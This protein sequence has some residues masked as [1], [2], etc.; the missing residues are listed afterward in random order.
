MGGGFFDAERT[1]LEAHRFRKSDKA[2]RGFEPRLLDSGSRVLAVT[3]R[4]RV[5]IRAYSIIRAGL[6][7]AFLKRTLHA[8][9]LTCEGERREL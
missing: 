7:A 3:P 4:G 2:L 6:A 9:T 5:I 1:G 8:C